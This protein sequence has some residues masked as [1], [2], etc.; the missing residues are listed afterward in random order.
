MLVQKT[1]A[2]SG[3]SYWEVVLLERTE[4][5]LVTVLHSCDA[6]TLDPERDPS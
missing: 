1:I 4:Y 2:N 5:G 6:W 3:Q